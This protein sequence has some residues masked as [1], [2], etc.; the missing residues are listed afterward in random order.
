MTAC[1][2]V[3]LQCNQVDNCSEGED[4]VGCAFE[5]QNG[6]VECLNNIRR[7]CVGGTWEN[8]EDCMNFDCRVVGDDTACIDPNPPV[9]EADETR[10]ENNVFERCEGGQWQIGEDCKDFVCRNIPDQGFGCV[11]PDDI[12][13]ADGFRRCDLENNRRQVCREDMWVVEEECNG[14]TE[15]RF[16]DATTTECF[17]PNAAVCQ[18]GQEQCNG[19]RPEVCV[20][21]QWAPGVA[22]AE[23][24]VCQESQP[25]VTE[26]V[27]FAGCDAGTERCNARGQRERCTD[28]SWTFLAECP[29]GLTC[30]VLDDGRSDCIVVAVCANGEQRCEQNWR[31]E[32]VDGQWVQQ[33]FCGNQRCELSVDG[34][35]Q[36]GAV[37][38]CQEGAQRCNF[39]DNIPETCTNGNW[40]EGNWCGDDAECTEVDGRAE[41]VDPNACVEGAARCLNDTR[42][43]CRNRNWVDEPC[44]N[45]EQC[46]ERDGGAICEVLDPCAACGDEFDRVCGADGNTYQNDCQATCRQVA[47]AH[48]G[49]CC[50]NNEQYSR[51]FLGR[52]AT[53]AEVDPTRPVFNPD[54][55]TCGRCADVTPAFDEARQ[56]CVTCVEIDMNQPYWNANTSSCEA[57][58][59]DRPLWNN[60]ECVACPAD[61]PVWDAD[62]SRCEACPQ[63]QPV[64][65]ENA[66][67][68]EACQGKYPGLQPGHRSMRS[69]CDAETCLECSD[70]SV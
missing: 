49:A 66:R 39:L 54:D 2:D 36:C 15:C 32:C 67:L 20:N 6:E 57:C 13:C 51:C 38:G 23:G 22:C 60:A 70:Q 48:R 59:N 65:N 30:T 3:A 31:E 41:C 9:C 34:D 52:C 56:Q 4:E 12:G 29:N 21:G 27:E 16:I 64:F 46:A 45:G 68:C 5:C 37:A 50:I 58:P 24:F 19:D 10:C 69:M 35:A 44:G 11:N 53:C 42:Q 25:G 43:I 40:V 28:N 63:D 17:D 1:I 26:C 18:D 7:T 62:A 47:V 8:I 14:D 33:S 61:Q 55:G